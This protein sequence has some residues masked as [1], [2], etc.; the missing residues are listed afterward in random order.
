MKKLLKKCINLP[1]R[2]AGF[3]I[4]RYVPEPK[5]VLLPWNT[6]PEFTAINQEIQAQSLMNPLKLYQLYE[7]ARSALSV[8]G[9]MA[10]IG[11]YKGGSAKMLNF[12][13]QDTQKSLHLFDTFEGMPETDPEKDLHQKGDFADTSLDR[14][15]AFVGKSQ[16]IHYYP[17]FF[18]ETFDLPDK[19]F[20]LVHI[21]VDIYQSVLDCCSIF[22]PQM[23]PGGLMVF[24]DYGFL[25]LPIENARF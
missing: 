9:E 8:P 11:V 1:L 21:D 3:E 17:G 20:C 18:P 7:F 15:K 24:D 16:W 19:Q 5:G 22:Y 2:K 14:V 12:L 25:L 6:D 4:C 13:I 23:S 10:E